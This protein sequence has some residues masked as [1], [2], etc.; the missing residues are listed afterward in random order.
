MIDRRQ[1]ASLVML[2]SMQ[3]F[4]SGCALPTVTAEERV[5]KLFTP[6]PGKAAVYLIA[7]EVPP[8]PVGSKCGPASAE[9]YSLSVNNLIAARLPYLRYTVIFVEPVAIELASA[10][11]P[12]PVYYSSGKCDYYL[13]DWKSEESI[14]IFD[15][16]PGSVYFF[17]VSSPGSSYN[18]WEEIDESRVHAILDL[19]NPSNKTPTWKSRHFGYYKAP[20]AHYTDKIFDRMQCLKACQIENS[21]LPWKKRLDTCVEHCAEFFDQ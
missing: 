7:D 18:K 17:E 16:K 4:L 14:K 21:S 1:T 3:I 19:P 2:A 11:R 5:H 13:G 6:P 15:A 9:V 10:W 12:A 8:P 20:L